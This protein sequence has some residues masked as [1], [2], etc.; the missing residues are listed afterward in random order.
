[1]ATSVSDPVTSCPSLSM[2][3][4]LSPLRPTLCTALFHLEVEIRPSEP[5]FHPPPRAWLLC[6]E[7]RG[8]NLLVWEVLGHESSRDGHS[9][10][11]RRR[12]GSLSEDLRQAGGWGCRCYTLSGPEHGDRVGRSGPCVMRDKRGADG[13]RTKCVTVRT[14]LSHQ[15]TG[16]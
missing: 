16:S 1:M 9:R 10:R 3:S 14:E 13:R 8:G 2:A 12:E 7:H 6:Q 5:A 4:V 11:D 15:R